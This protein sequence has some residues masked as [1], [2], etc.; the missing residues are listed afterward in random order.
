MAI[1]PQNQSQ[2]LF[3]TKDYCVLKK[4]NRSSRIKATVQKPLCLC[5]QRQANPYLHNS[6]FLQLIFN[7]SLIFHST[8][9]KL[10][11]KPSI[12]ASYQI[13]VHL[14]TRFQ[15]RRSFRNNQ[16]KKLPTVAM[17]VNRSGRNEQ[18]LYRTFHRY[19]L[20]SFGSFDHKRFQRRI[21]F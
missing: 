10:Y 5:T 11:T 7:L 16:E 20:P 3:C 8:L 18:S 4:M 15:R 2:L 12:G 1:F 6:N 17:F 19:F 21:F 9:R 14:V 13:S